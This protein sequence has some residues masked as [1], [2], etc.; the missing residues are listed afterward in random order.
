MGD[1]G[2]EEQR[3]WEEAR[4]LE[5]LASDLLKRHPKRLTIKAVEAAAWE[6]GLS[7]ATMY[8]VTDRYRSMRA[9]SGLLPRMGTPERISDPDGRAGGRHPRGCTSRVSEA[10]APTSEP[11]RRACAV[12]LPPERLGAAHLAHGQSHSSG[13]RCAHQSASPR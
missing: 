13:N 5:V 8:R 7:R 4:R 6:L 12:A 10:D 2:E 3:A 1:D 9:V 11:P